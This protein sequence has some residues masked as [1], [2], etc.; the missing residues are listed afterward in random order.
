[1]TAARTERLAALLIGGGLAVVT[2]IWAAFGVAGWTLGTASRTER[3]VIHGP[4]KALR[5][6]AGRDEVALAAGS[7][8]DVVV[9][10][11]SRGSFRAPTPHVEVNGTSIRVSGGCGRL[12]FGH[13]HA[14]V[15]VHLPPATAV[16]VSSASGDVSAAGLSGPVRVTT[17]SGD[18]SVS[19]LGGPAEL[20]TSSGDLDA[21]A[22]SGTAALQSS[23]GDVAGT[24]LSART[25]D[26]HAGSGD[27]DLLFAAA[28]TSV[29][30]ATGSG[31]VSLL[32][33]PGGAYAVDAETSSGERAV[34]VRTDPQAGHVL[35]ARTG[36]GDVSVL[37][38]G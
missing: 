6:D 5:I 19:D 16:E 3:R 33:P 4:V 31:D 32:V 25:V 34:G 28:P 7:G 10:S 29:D 37:Y 22:L 15:T 30:A 8:R 12:W 38:A 23:S 36:S 1:M 21:H 14:T 11:R 24:D 17:S 20:H 18:V 9:E 35:R 26:A 13:C 2:V 27:L